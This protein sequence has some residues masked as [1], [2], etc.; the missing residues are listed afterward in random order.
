M[1]FSYH[2]PSEPGVFPFFFKTLKDIDELN[3]SAG[4]IRM[5]AQWLVLLQPRK[6]CP[7]ITE[8]LLTGK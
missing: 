5:G 4:F 6:T 8:K 3:P 7:N 1:I 2:C